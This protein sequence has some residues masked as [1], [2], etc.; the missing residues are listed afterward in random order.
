[1]KSHIL[2]IALFAALQTTSA[3]A[4]SGQLY[5]LTF[6]GA[7]VAVARVD[8]TTGATTPVVTTAATSYSQSAAT[9]D[10][11]GGR[12]FFKS[13]SSLYIVNVRD[14]TS[15]AVTVGSCCALLQFDYSSGTLYGVD[16]SG[17]TVVIRS[18]DLSS[19]ATT[20]VMSTAASGVSL[21]QPA[22]NPA[23]RTLFFRD[24]IQS[25]LYEVD[26]LH[27]SSSQVPLANCCAGYA[28][29]PAAGRLYGLDTSGP[30][31]LL[32]SI[33]LGTGSKTTLLNTGASGVALV[34]FAFDAIGR[35][36]F[37]EGGTQLHTIDVPT[38]STTHLSMASCCPPLFF[39]IDASAI[40]AL[41]WPFLFLMLS[42]LLVAGV[43]KVTR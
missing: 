26:L 2:A 21:V 13:G 14:A 36:L 38:L 31:T 16:S 5:A 6:V 9:V 40:P 4:A 32:V 29:D 15:A 34:P 12:I 37:F 10:V 22:F 33:D 39:I 35:R 24:G 27:G 30:S 20:F 18:I 7:Q 17:P 42:S 41:S 19:G 8:L 23:T 1:M 3:V 43:L 28:F 25:S 11:L